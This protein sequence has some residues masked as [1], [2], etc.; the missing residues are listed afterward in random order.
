MFRTPYEFRDESRKGKYLDIFEVL[1]LTNDNGLPN[2]REV[3]RK[4]MTHS[5][6]TLQVFLILDNILRCFP[7]SDFAVYMSL[8]S[9][10]ELS[11]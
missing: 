11:M 5:T 1:Y 8:Y 10:Y 9:S 3:C 6:R 4:I 7:S 2:E